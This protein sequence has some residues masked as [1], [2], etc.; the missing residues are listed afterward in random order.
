M[1]LVRSLLVAL[2][3]LALL[4]PAADASPIASHA[5]VHSCC[6]PYAMKE[7]IF[8]ES[9]A[10]GAGSIRVDV[11]LNAIFDGPKPN[12][13][14][15]DQVIELSRRYQLPVLGILLHPPASITTCAERGPEGVR[16][17]ARDPEQFGRLA[18]QVAVHAHGVIDDWEILN[19]PDGAWAFTGTPEQYGA[20]LEA[21]SR[22]I[23]STVPGARI[24][25]GGIM[26]PTSLDWVSRA[27]TVPGAAGAYD[28]ANVHLRGRG[29]GLPQHLANWRARFAQHGFNGP[30]WV[31]EHG[32]P[33]DPAHQWDRSYVGG[34]EAQAAYLSESIPLLA[35]AGAE[36]IFVTLRDNL[37]GA[38][39]S[40]GV[41]GLHE[42]PGFPA[43]HKPAYGAVQRLAQNWD[44]VMA[45]RAAA[46]EQLFREAVLKI[47]AQ[48][49]DRKARSARSRL[50][51]LRAAAKRAQ[52]R[53]G[54]VW[55][56]GSRCKPGRRARAASP[57]LRGHAVQACRLRA[58][59][60]KAARE[61]RRHKSDAATKRRLSAT[62]ARSAGDLRARAAGG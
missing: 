23:R 46:R 54:R 24:V 31:T 36:R 32:Y 51:R 33:A 7:R 53:A 14:G 39:A 41:L 22:H 16:C 5:M 6:T 26:E 47:Q 3:A 45:L 37:E 11:E 18:A 60:K 8:A 61:L 40:E 43:A 29:A 4:A 17:A 52:R 42:T 19:E 56:K 57:R 49:S 10:M 44:L 48:A 35:E 62:H 58:R 38:W 15:L 13:R 2:A 34:Q 1:A 30:I 59:V 50:R 25:F 9:K 55:V 12:W 20:Q 21:A 28:I 27:L